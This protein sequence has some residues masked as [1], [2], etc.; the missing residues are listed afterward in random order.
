M[1]RLPLPQDLIER[2]NAPRRAALEDEYESLGRALERRGRSIDQVKQ[3]VKAFAVAVP[4]WGLGVGGTRFAKFPI[5]GEPITIHEK[6][7]D[8]AVVNQ[9]GRLTPTASPHFPW[10]KVDDPASLREEAAELGLGFDAVNSN[11]FQD[12]PG[13]GWSYKFGSLT[14][15]DKAVRDQAIAHN[16]DCIDLG[17]ALGSKAITVWIGDGA[18]FPGQQN[19]TKAFDRYLDSMSQIYAALPTDWRMFMEHK[20]YE[21]AFYS[22]VISDWG[23]NLIAAQQLG[24]KACCLVD[25]GHHAPNVNI[26]QI[27]ARLARFGKLGGFHFNDSKYGDDDLDTGSINPHQLFLIFNELVE[28]EARANGDFHPAYMIDQSHNVT[29]PIESLLLSAGAIAGSY[30]RALIVDREALDA[31]QTGNDVVS[32]F[33]D[34]RRAYETDVAPILAM[35]R[36]ELGGAIDPIDTYRASEWRPRKAQERARASAAAGIV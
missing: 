11:T 19:Q 12:Q 32:A 3:R 26:E 8:A 28:A 6:L 9:L 20:L 29:D 35:A 24:D 1:T 23:T 17:V 4:T 36:L 27:V 13:Q 25:L 7:E 10:D 21:P 30:A 22:T 2:E 15:T 14:H 33:Q 31:H 34:L 5:P 18:N 16:I